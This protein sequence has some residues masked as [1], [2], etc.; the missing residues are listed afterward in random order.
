MLFLWQIFAGWSWVD[1]YSDKDI[2]QIIYDE[3]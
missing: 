1:G 2:F 3:F